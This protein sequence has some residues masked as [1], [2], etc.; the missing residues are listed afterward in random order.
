[1]LFAG[2]YSVGAESAA[3]TWSP[4]TPS[5]PV[6]EVNLEPELCA[7]ALRRAEEWF[8]S[9]AANSW[10][11]EVQL[12]DVEVVD[13]GEEIPFERGG[14]R[15]KE[16][17]L[18]GNE[19][20]ERILISRSFSRDRDSFDGLIVQGSVDVALPLD[21][22]GIERILSVP[23]GVSRFPGDEA[24]LGPG[25][26]VGPTPLYRWKGR[27]YFSG[28]LQSPA[29]SGFSLYRLEA[30][31]SAP[32]VCLVKSAEA[33]Q[34]AGSMLQLPE[35]R[36]LVKALAAIGTSGRSYC[37]TLYAGE[38]HDD[39]AWGSVHRAA[40]RP[41]AAPVSDPDIESKTRYFEYSARMW[42]FLETWAA[43][44]VWNEREYRTLRQSVEPARRAYADYLSRE[45]G[46]NDRDARA[47]GDAALERMIASWFLIPY[48]FDTEGWPAPAPDLS[49][50]RISLDPAEQNPF[51][52]TNLMVAAH[53]NRLDLVRELLKRGADPAAATRPTDSY[54]EFNVQRGGRTALTYAAE[55]ASPLVMKVLLDAGAEP[56]VTDTEGNRL[57]FYLQRNPRLTEEQRKLPIVELAATAASLADAPGFDCTRARRRAER[58]ICADEGL[59]LLDA[60]MTEAYTGALTRAGPALKSEQS[61]WIAAREKDC[62]ASN[63]DDYKECLAD[64]TAAR[65]RFLHYLAEPVGLP[66]P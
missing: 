11:L 1:M 21:S 10:S 54:C 27:F 5:W 22:A 59:R 43:N 58:A 15:F 31:G 8:A 46:L 28:M 60:E 61:G 38:R 2:A 64:A 48:S 6:L 55:N 57:D 41:W 65:V 25:W 35:I 56:D 13:F 19:T 9:E 24:R 4:R 53:M 7:K 40:T 49:R 23:P 45:F 44:D 34:V 29:E 18:D 47:K 33:V 39:W 51:G 20:A 12:P 36:T 17:N 30:D 32:L 63:G 62:A 66:L 50:T 42:R 26:I 14:V 37:G 3:R 16:L 52:K